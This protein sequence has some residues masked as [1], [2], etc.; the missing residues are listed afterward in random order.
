MQSWRGAEAKWAN[1]APK[2]MSHVILNFDVL[3]IVDFFFVVANIDFLKYCINILLVLM[4]G[5]W[6]LP[7]LH[8]A[9]EESAPLTSP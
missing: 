6:L 3:L 4:T 1:C 2:Y 8:L 9:F 7:S 5:F